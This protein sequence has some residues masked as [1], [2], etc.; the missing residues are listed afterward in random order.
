VRKIE[1]DEEGMMWFWVIPSFGIYSKRR[2]QLEEKV[3]KELGALGYSPKED[4][5]WIVVY[6]TDKGLWGKLR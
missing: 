6:M 2:V 3:A 4:E 1:K 5:R